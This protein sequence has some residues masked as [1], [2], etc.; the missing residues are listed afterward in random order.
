[1][2]FSENVPRGVPD[3]LK[4]LAEHPNSLGIRRAWKLRVPVPVLASCEGLGMPRNHKDFAVS[5]S[6]NLYRAD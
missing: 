5:V 1:M 2:C 4:W 3:M 6:V